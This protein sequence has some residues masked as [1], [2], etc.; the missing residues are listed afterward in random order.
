MPYRNP[1]RVTVPP[2]RPSSMN[3]HLFER[4]Q[5]RRRKARRTNALLGG[6][7]AVIGGFGVAW[8]MLRPSE[9]P[10]KLSPTGDTDAPESFVL[11]EGE[12]NGLPSI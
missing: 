1:R 4:R 6:A 10:Q 11:L 12:E 8:M 2:F 9:P 3:A 5:R 7:I